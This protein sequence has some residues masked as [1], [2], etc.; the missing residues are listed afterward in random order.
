M[1]TLKNVNLGSKSYNF[2]QCQ[3]SHPNLTLNSNGKGK[4]PKI[5]LPS[6]KMEKC[7]PPVGHC[8]NVEFGQEGWTLQEIEK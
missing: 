3:P 5:P 2:F 1:S 4:I 8:F 7:N 6:K